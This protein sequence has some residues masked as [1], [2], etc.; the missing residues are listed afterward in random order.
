[1]PDVDGLT[2]VKF[3]RAN[4]A[5]AEVPMIV[6]SS[7]EEAVTKADCFSAGANDYLVKLPDRVELVARLRYHS[8][9]Y[10]HLLERNAAH[11]E[12]AAS[13][14]HL[15]DEIAAG[16]K[17]VRSLLPNPWLPGQGASPIALDWRFVPSAEM[18]G[19]ALGYHSLDPDHLALYLLDVTGHGLAS[20]LLGVTVL[21]VLRTGSLPNTDFRDPGRVLFGLNEA[22]PCEKH[23]EKFFT[24]WYGVYHTPSR[25]LRWSG[26]GHPAGLLFP[27][28]AP[29]GRPPCALDSQGPMI[30]MMPW[31]AFEVAERVVPPRSRLF[32]YSDGAHEIH[33]T[34]GTDWSFDEFVG[35]LTDLAAHEPDRVMDALLAHIRDLHGGDV[36]DD[37]FSMLDVRF[38]P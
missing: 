8:R 5:T 2:L 20:A 9:G 14:K 21:N 37:D 29:P 6:L 10:T 13:R 24:I 3:L 16:E 22:F 19:D 25:L 36:L 38:G 28:D 11:A 26:G 30:G 35:T 1:M 7:R 15:A 32:L 23:G 34:D 33:R 4:P 27:G 17:Y 18:G 12:L 31:P